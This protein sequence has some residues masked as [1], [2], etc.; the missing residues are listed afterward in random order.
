MYSIKENYLK[1]KDYLRKYIKLE[2]ET[3]WTEN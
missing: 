1:P 3:I 2:N